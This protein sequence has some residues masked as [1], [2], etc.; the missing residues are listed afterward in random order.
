M[1]LLFVCA[2]VLLAIWLLP[3]SVFICGWAIPANIITVGGIL[4]LLIGYKLFRTCIGIHKLI[5]K[6]TFYVKGSFKKVS[7][8]FY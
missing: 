4:F 6:A 3:P 1:K 8:S 5:K 7:Y 2:K